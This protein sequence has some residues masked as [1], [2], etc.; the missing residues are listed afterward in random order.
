[1]NFLELTVVAKYRAAAGASGTRNIGS[2][3][4]DTGRCWLSS[5]MMLV[6]AA[7]LAMKSLLQPLADPSVVGV[8]GRLEAIV[9]HFAATGGSPSSSTG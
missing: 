7:Q 8:G 4:I 3:S 2:S 6:A 5:M 9:E 1:M